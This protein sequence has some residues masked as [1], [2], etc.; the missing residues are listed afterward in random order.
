MG[1]IV[2]GVMSGM[3]AQLIRIYFMTELEEPKKLT[4]KD[5]KELTR[6]RLIDAALSVVLNGGYA[7]F[8]MRKVTKKAGIA[9]PSFYSHFDTM[10]ELLSAVF[11]RLRIH[12]L[13]PMQN[14]LLTMLKEGGEESLPLLFSR[15]YSLVFDFYLSNPE[16]FCLTLV[17]SQSGSTVGNRYRKEYNS[18]RDMWSQF[19]FDNADVLGGAIEKHQSDMVV[20]ALF[21]MIDSL[22]LGYIE[23]RYSDKDAMVEMLTS[24]TLHQLSLLS[25]NKQ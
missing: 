19:F 15:M 14:M 23:K 4:R 21:G 24:F 1:D 20:D 8:T 9:Q 5:K 25:A 2:S 18:L 13:Y 6:E 11:A 3:A 12:Y 10:D 17:D 16:L 7:N 22:L